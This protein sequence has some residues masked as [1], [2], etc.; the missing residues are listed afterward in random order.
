VLAC[1]IRVFSH[2]SLANFF[3]G[4]YT[5]SESSMSSGGDMTPPGLELNQN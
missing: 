2:S 3:A 5:R 4:E 1:G